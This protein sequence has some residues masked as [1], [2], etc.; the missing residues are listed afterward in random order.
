MYAYVAV[1]QREV[2]I[3]DLVEYEFLPRFLRAGDHVI[4]MIDKRGRGSCGNRFFL[5]RI[6]EFDDIFVALEHIIFMF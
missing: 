6:F 5:I 4:L 1:L 3:I 2:L